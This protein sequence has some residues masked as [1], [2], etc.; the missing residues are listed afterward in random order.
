MTK[1]E[2]WRWVLDSG[3]VVDGGG[4]GGSCDFLSC[5]V[6]RALILSAIE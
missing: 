6:D 5:K 4:D 1:N 3:E 2:V